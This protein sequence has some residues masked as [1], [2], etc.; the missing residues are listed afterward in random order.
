MYDI[1]SE[2]KD[3]STKEVTISI[4]NRKAAFKVANAVGAKVYKKDSVIT[5]KD[6]D[7]AIGSVHT[8][9][10]NNGK[11]YA[12]SKTGYINGEGHAHLFSTFEGALRFALNHYE[13]TYEKIKNV[14]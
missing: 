2:I 3:N 9:P 5:F 14:A 10:S 7:E 1:F 6:K 13:V 8:Y 12:T 11:F 4:I